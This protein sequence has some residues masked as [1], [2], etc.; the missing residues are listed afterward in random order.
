[1]KRTRRNEVTEA[2][3]RVAGEIRAEIARQGLTQ[4]AVAERCARSGQWLSYKL[5]GTSAITIAD[6]ELIA[7]V[8]NVPAAKFLAP[9]TAWPPAAPAPDPPTTVVAYVP[10]YTTPA[11]PARA[12]A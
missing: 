6:V 3:R 9:P 5:N 10:M 4:R 12:A 7:R 8:L 2:E 11:P 1:M